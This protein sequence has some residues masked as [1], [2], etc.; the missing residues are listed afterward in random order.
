MRDKISISRVQALHPSI[1]QDVKSFITEA[2]ESLNVTLRI[3][4]G[5][6]TIDEQNALYAKGRTTP[7]P[8]VTNAKGGSSYHNYGLAIDLVEIKD[9]TANWNFDYKK[10]LPWSEKYGFTW[11]GSFKSIVDKP[12]FEKTFGNHWKELL[13]KH[14]AGKFITGTKYVLLQEVTHPQQNPTL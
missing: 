1:R 5:L 2:E 14:N 4:Q 6:R 10:L 3:V 7:G 8:K 11:G 12:H 9:L 13:A